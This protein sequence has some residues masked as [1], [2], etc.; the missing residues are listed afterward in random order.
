MISPNPQMMKWGSFKYPLSP[1]VGGEVLTTDTLCRPGE[2]PLDQ[3][4]GHS[5]GHLP[6]ETVSSLPGAQ[7]SALL[8]TLSSE[9]SL[10]GT[11]RPPLWL[12]R[13]AAGREESAPIPSLC[14]K[15]C[16]P[17]HFLQEGFS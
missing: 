15:L 11:V 4:Q 17:A 5:T 3:A 2:Q 8:D 13:P 7:G 6:P 14:P 16:L 10:K 12:G 1:G 9:R